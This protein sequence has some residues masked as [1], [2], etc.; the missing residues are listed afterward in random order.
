M[1]DKKTKVINLFGSPAVGKSTT[2]AE[3]YSVM[4]KKDLNVELVREY[5]KA[6]AW[7]NR[8][9]N[10]YDQI[11]FFGKQVRH[12]TLLYGRVDFLITDSPVLLASFYEEY[13]FHQRIILPSALNFIKD[14]KTEGIEYYDFWLERIEDFDP[15]GR[16]HTEEQANELHKDLN[17]WLKDCGVNLMSTGNSTEDR[18]DEILKVINGD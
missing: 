17:E 9:I 1:F 5:V 18:V 2:A 12:E 13:Y 4:K 3:L 6:W 7:E 15:E 11:Y 14:A 16:Y 8:K 10:R